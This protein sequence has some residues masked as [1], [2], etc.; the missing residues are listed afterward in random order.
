MLIG[1]T[2]LPV[3]NAAVR[4][5]LRMQRPLGTIGP[6]KWGCRYILVSLPLAPMHTANYM[7]LINADIWQIFG[8]KPKYRTNFDL[9]VALE[10]SDDHE[11]IYYSY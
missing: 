6:K 5:G 10:Q 9:M 1:F 2:R 7:P 3:A 4:H 11:R 8:H